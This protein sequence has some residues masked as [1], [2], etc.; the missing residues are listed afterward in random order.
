MFSRLHAVPASCVLLT[1]SGE[2]VLSRR[3]GDSRGQLSHMSFPLIRCTGSGGGL[4][5]RL[6]EEFWME[7]GSLFMGTAVIPWPPA[8]LR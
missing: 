2:Q 3:G 6:L 7:P 5:V 4:Y 8:G 1:F